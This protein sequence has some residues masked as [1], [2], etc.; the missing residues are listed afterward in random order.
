MAT[1]GLITKQIG[2]GTSQPP[3]PN[4]ARIKPVNMTKFLHKPMRKGEQKSS[5]TAGL[6]GDF[7]ITAK[8]SQKSHIGMQAFSQL[9]D[10]K[11]PSRISS[12]KRKREA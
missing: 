9:S 2:A 10:S 4:R 12:V 8:Q 3:S 5:M 11:D 6:V 1:T 7:G